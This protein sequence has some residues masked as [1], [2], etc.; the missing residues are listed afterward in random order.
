MT[1]INEIDSF[2]LILKPQF[3]EEEQ[4]SFNARTHFKQLGSWSSLTAML[5]VNEIDTKYD[6][7]L[8]VTELNKAETLSD[9]FEIVK[10]RMC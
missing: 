7:L 2:L 8:S 6:V 1:L 5:V 3:L 4:D 10:T 9:L